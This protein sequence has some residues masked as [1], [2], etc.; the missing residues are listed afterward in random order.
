MKKSKRSSG[1][2]RYERR[3][4]FYPKHYHLPPMMHPLMRPY[5]SRGFLTATAFAILFAVIIISECAG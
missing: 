2:W 1:A 5:K 4:D 3:S